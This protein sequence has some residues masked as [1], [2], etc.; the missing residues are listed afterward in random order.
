MLADRFWG[1][2]VNAV[3]VNKVTVSVFFITTLLSL[4]LFLRS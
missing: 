4:L 3:L 2:D 1:R